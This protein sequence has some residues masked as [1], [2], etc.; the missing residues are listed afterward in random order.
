MGLKWTQA[1]IEKLKQYYGTKMLFELF[2]YRTKRAV[3][4]QAAKLGF[5]RNRNIPLLSLT[6]AQRGYLAGL[7]DGDGTITMVWSNHNILYPRVA[8]SVSDYRLC[9]IVREYIGIGHIYSTP[10]RGKDHYTWVVHTPQDVIAVL[11]ELN[12]YFVL[13]KRRADLML[14]FCQSRLNRR[15]H[16]RYTE[17]DLEL[18]RQ[19]REA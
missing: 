17:E 15:T 7:I 10:T 14:R 6:D 1:E 12:A 13:K 9:H 18:A 11:T 16:A 2:P 8:I 4:T 19:I 3:K 5:K